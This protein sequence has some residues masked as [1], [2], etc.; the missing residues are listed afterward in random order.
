MWCCDDYSVGTRNLLAAQALRSSHFADYSVGTRKLKRDREMRRAGT[1]RVPCHRFSIDVRTA[2]TP[3]AR[4]VGS[5]WAELA[6]CDAL[7]ELEERACPAD[8]QTVVGFSLRGVAPALSLTAL[9]PF[10][11]SW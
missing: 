7:Q 5:E 10:L 2:R 3:T 11:D 1:S 6:G 9:L 8:G 4:Q